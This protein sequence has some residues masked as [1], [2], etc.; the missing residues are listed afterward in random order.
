VHSF[1]LI[2]AAMA[3]G[4]VAAPTPAREVAYAPAPAWRAPPPEPTG[5]PT[6]EGA[7]YRVVYSDTQVRVADGEVETFAAYRLKILKPEALDV[8]NIVLSWQ[9]A[10]GRATVHAVRILR[11]GV[12]TDVLETTKFRVL[13][14]EQNL[15]RAALDGEYTAA[16]QVPGLQVGDELEVAATISQRD[17]TLGDR[18]FGAGQLPVAGLPGAFRYRLL[19]PAGH[20]IRWQTSPDLDGRPTKSGDGGED[21]VFELRDPSPSVPTEGAPPRYNVRRFVEYSDF[22][23]WADLSKRFWPLYQEASTLAPNS[24][25]RRE[26]K[27]IAASATTPAERV[28]AA[29]A[30]VQDQ[31]RYVYV[32]LDGGNYRPA[33]ADQTWERRFGDCKAKTVLLLALL[34]E[35]RIEAEPVLG[36]L[37]GGDGTDQRLPSPAQFNHVLVRARIGTQS[38]WLDGTRLG[39]KSLDRLPAPAFRWALPVRKA[40]AGLEPVPPE[41][42]RSPQM[43]QVADLDSSAGTDKPA[44]VSLKRILRGDEVQPIRTQLASLSAE[45]ATRMLRDYW[46]NAESWVQ[47]DAVAWSYDEP[48]GALVL[49]LTG[50]GDLDWSGDS[51]SG[52]SLSINGAGF[53]P[54]E[55]LRRPADQDASAPWATDYPLYRCWATTVHLPA[56]PAGWRWA[57]QAGS[58]S[59]TLGGTDYWRRAG[60]TG[61]V[62]RTVMSRRVAV[63]EIPAAEAKALN[64]QIPGFDN[65]MSQVFEQRIPLMASPANTDKPPFAEP[66]DWIANSWAC[67]H[68]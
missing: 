18:A 59:R 46:R 52:H 7:A 17:P 67:G 54:P 16:L 65:N 12:P 21:L 6:P 14:R 11:G 10:G 40:G 24:P 35:L 51:A 53:Y 4:P 3:A 68:G 29:L 5:A 9:P 36:N 33:P 19:W 61:N 47:A 31:V 8:G 37:A 62:M 26:A 63:P 28:E 43:L 27:R 34:K 55:R 38:Y 23:S 58:M 57:Y 50:T 25:L 42:P 39:D 56:A 64:D 48:S 20:A 66:T 49:S 32:G 60:L 2:A 30:L 15:E 41:P 45:G 13:E 1:I 44:K 22:A